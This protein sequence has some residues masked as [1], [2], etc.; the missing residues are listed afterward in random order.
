MIT[1]DQQNSCFTSLFI[2]Y[3]R[4]DPPV[5]AVWFVILHVLSLVGSL[6]GEDIVRW[7]LTEAKPP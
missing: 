3:C 5:L 2:V 6:F 7:D 4:R 1:E